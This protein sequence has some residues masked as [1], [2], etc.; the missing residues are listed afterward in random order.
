M[1]Q[2]STSGGPD[3]KLGSCQV[4]V[5]ASPVSEAHKNVDGRTDTIATAYIMLACSVSHVVKI[6]NT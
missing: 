3:L 6:A 4:A 5:Y 1:R 2:N